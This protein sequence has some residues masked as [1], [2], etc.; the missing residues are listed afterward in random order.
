M[1]LSKQILSQLNGSVQS[2]PVK[3]IFDLPEKVLQFGTGVLL[4]GLPDY[5][6][7]KANKQGIFN[8]RIVVVKSTDSGGLDAYEIQNGLFTHCIKGISQGK[9][10]EEYIVNASISRVL[11]AKSQWK[12]VLACAANPAMEIIISNTTEVGIVLVEN[13]HVNGDPPVSFPAKLLAFLFERYKLFQGDLTKGMVIVP[14]ELITDNGAKLQSIVMELAHLNKF[15]YSFIDWLETANCFC[16]SLVDRIVPGKLPEMQHKKTEAKL[17]YSDELM[18]MSEVYGLWAIESSNSN[19]KEV[20]SFAKAD[21]TILITANIK[22]HRELKLRLLNGTHSFTCGLA[23]LAGFETVK[24]AME[25]KVM[26][27]LIHDLILHEIAPC[28]NKELISETEANDFSNKILDRFRN[29]FLDHQ[30]ISIS[31][32]YTHKMK[33]RNV[34]LLQKHFEHDL[35]VPG[36]MAMGFA[37]YLLFMRCAPGESG[38][39]YGDLNGVAYPVHDERAGYFHQLWNNN[40]AAEVV[41]K[42]LSNENLWDDDLTTLPGFTFAVQGYLDSMMERGVLATLEEFHFSREKVD[43]NKS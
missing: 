6:I 26:S 13:D 35:Y 43:I 23:L 8:G 33:M 3:E 12:E 40:E 38:T 9:I 31:L 24:E 17:G 1:Q 36:L 2:V 19:V 32:H 20:L 34:P 21:E 22:K 11:S 15:E 30:W 39:Y 41:K 7:D 10:T 14:T 25:N 5:Y 42:A 18:I 16:N 27:L 37:G 28:L 4:C 29:P